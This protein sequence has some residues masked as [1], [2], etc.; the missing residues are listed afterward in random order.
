MKVALQYWNAAGRSQKCRFISRQR[1]YHGSTLGALSL[2]GFAERRAP[3]EH[4]LLDVAFVSAANTYRPLNGAAASELVGVLA[5][6]LDER[7]RTIGAQNVA[8]FIFEPVVGAA[9]G[10]VPAPP[11]Y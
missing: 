8:A 5:A 1:S 7:I 4:S 3:F 6:E 10:V 9:G 11:G 2:S